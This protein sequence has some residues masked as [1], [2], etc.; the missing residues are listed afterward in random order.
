MKRSLTIGAFLLALMASG[1]TATQS[2]TPAPQAQPDDGHRDA[3]RD[4]DRD[5]RQ[6]ADR[7][8]A[9][10]ASCPDGQ[11]AVTDRDGK[12]GCAQN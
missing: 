3:D 12:T 9:R 7:D 8:H 1:C 11:H 5:K 2:A 10:P 6:E 4:R